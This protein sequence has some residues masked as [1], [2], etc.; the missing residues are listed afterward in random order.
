MNKRLVAIL[1]PLT[2]ALSLPAPVAAT[3]PPGAVPS[4]CVRTVA[5][6]RCTIGPFDVGAG[7]TVEMMTGVA[8]PSEAG[9]MTSAHAKLVDGSGRALEHHL[10]HMHHAVWLNPYEEDMT[11][12][13]YDGGAFPG[14]ERFFA[15]G[16]ELTKVDLP[17]GYGYFWDPQVS[18][19]Y[20]QSAPWWGFTVH[21]DGMHGASEAYI[22]LDM[23]F[24]AETEAKAM[25]N[26][27]PAW[28]DVRNCSS[29]PVYDVAKG[30]GRNGV[31]REH[32]TYKMRSS[33]RF[34]FLAGH[35]H[36]G[37]LRTSLKNLT[38]GRHIYT[39]T[40]TYASADDRR[41]LTKMSSWSGL[42]G[43][44]VSE[45]DKLRLTAVYDS[46]QSIEGAMGIM[47]GAFVPRR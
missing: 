18:Q 2:A 28:F 47:V 23:G 7:E 15:T 12:D 17:T 45:G 46:T 34:V 29:E 19:S 1:L 33:G 44:A 8:A 43:I 35:L 4:Y 27:E 25:R 40:A 21:L 32:W 16:N 42:P 22:Q 39:S 10:V 3:P 9:Y 38:T 37:G 11:C 14:Y 26:I 30:S 13:S 41:H 36:D 5:G 31:H 24:V 20:T 6:Y